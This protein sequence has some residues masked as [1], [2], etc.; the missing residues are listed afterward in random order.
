MLNVKKT[1]TKLLNCDLV[2][3]QGTETV[4]GVTWTYRKWSS[5]IA[6]CW[7][8]MTGATGSDGRYNY[9]PSC[10]SFFTNSQ[11]IVNASGWSQGYV[12]TYAG[13]TRANYISNNWVIDGY[14]E[15]G[16]P[17]NSCGVCVS[18]KGKWK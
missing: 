11:I 5:G 7:T 3:A 16:A 9:T 17:S 14:L 18:V 1:L 15:N 12:T 10:P 4:S 2:V 13:Y 6:E 8:Y